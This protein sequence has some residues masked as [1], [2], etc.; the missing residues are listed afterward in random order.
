MHMN[1]G[2][3]RNFYARLELRHMDGIDEA[4]KDGLLQVLSLQ[5]AP[6]HRKQGHATS[7]LKAVCKEADE[8]KKILVLSPDDKS[9]KEW[10]QKFGFQAIQF[11]PVVLMCREPKVKMHYDIETDTFH[12]AA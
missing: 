10:Y 6:E 5:T 8:A 9:L 2:T 3:R 4:A 11:Q 12:E 1:P 7:L